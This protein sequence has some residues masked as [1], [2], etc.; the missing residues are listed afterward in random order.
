MQ[1]PSQLLE[2]RRQG[3]SRQRH[4]HA[5][6]RL[7][8][9]STPAPARTAIHRTSSTT[10]TFAGSSS[11]ACER[12]VSARAGTLPRLRPAR[13]ETARPSPRYRQDSARQHSGFAYLALVASASPCRCRALNAVESP[14]LPSLRMPQKALFYRCIVETAD[15]EV[16]GAQRVRSR[17][18][19]PAPLAASAVHAKLQRR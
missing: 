5:R 19:R 3:P 11:S 12:G 8:T 1:G 4:R 13:S 10:T 9:P 7:T 2:Q 14:N 17:G 18:I 6:R 15:R 16:P